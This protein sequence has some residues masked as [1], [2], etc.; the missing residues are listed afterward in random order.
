M[1]AKIRAPRWALDYLVRSRPGPSNWEAEPPSTFNLSRVKTFE[2]GFFEESKKE[3]TGIAVHRRSQR[4]PPGCRL[5]NSR[6]TTSQARILDE[7]GA[8]DATIHNQI[9]SL[10]VGTAK[11]LFLLVAM[12]L[13]YEDATLYSDRSVCFLQ[14]GEGDK[15]FADAYTCRMMR[16]DWPKACYR[17][18]ASLMLMKDYEKACGAL[19]DGLK[20]DPRNLEIENALRHA[21]S[22]IQFY[23][24]LYFIQDANSAT[25]AVTRAKNL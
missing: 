9:V 13:D 8:T 21:I 16:P 23:C 25:L 15:A 11:F 17:Q 3:P 22:F 7:L 5:K 10:L 20:M 1:L 6:S 14:I 12:G 19:F 4:S 24:T 18:G 2:A